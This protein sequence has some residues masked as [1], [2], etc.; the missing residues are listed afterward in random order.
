MESKRAAPLPLGSFYVVGARIPT[1]PLLGPRPRKLADL[2]APDEA[3]LDEIDVLHHL[4]LDNMS[5]PISDDLMPVD[6]G[7]ARRMRLDAHRLDV[8][9]D[10]APLTSPVVS[11]AAMAVDTPAFHPIRP[12]DISMHGG[13]RRVD[14][15]GVERA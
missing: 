6:H 7:A 13:Q 9:I 8:R 12:L 14:V 4:V 2:H 15:A 3:A 1:V 5:G 11:N 10:H